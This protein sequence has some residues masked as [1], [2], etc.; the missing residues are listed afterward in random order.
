[1]SRRCILLISKHS[2]FREALVRLL[3]EQLDVEMVEA[4]TWKEGVARFDDRPPDA[5][6]VD[7]EDLRLRD[8]DLAPLLWPGKN[9]LKVIYLTLSGDEMI[10]HHRERMENV[11][12]NDLV[13][14]LHVPTNEQEAG[15]K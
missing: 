11:T 8:V 5:V 9:T 6:V 14:A 12:S 1:M 13:R 10:V 4:T 7:H 15:S 3:M 2:I